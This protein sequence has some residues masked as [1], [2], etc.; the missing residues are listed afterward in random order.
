LD[1]SLR[2]GTVIVPGF[3]LSDDEALQADTA[4]AKRFG[5]L[6]DHVI[7]AGSQ[8]VSDPLEKRRLHLATKA[9]AIDLESGAVARVAQA[10][11]KPFLVIRAICDAAERNLPPAALIAMDPGG[12]IGL[13]PIVRS[14]LRQ[15][16]QIPN[17][18]LL[19]WDAMLARRA[20]VGLVRRYQKKISAP[21]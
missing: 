6:T 10:Y 21:G 3:V 9:H 19:G 4:L 5:A 18:A 2:P 11:G 7:L 17:L 8:I 12:E 13:K 15:P 20:L 16:G 1:P 14:V